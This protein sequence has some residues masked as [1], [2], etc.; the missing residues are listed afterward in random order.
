MSQ[1]G[2]GAPVAFF[3]PYRFDLSTRELRKGGLR[4]RLEGKPALILQHL[5]EHAGALVTREEL[6]ALLW[7]PGVHVD[8][9]HGLNKAINRLRAVL[10]DDREEPRYIETLSRRGYRFVA[11]LEFREE[12]AEAAS[13][14]AA[15]VSAAAER[16]AENVPALVSYPLV[17]WRVA[18]AA[19]F[20]LLLTSVTYV[21][22][23]QLHADANT[24]HARRIVVLPFQNLT[25]DEGQEYFCDGLTDELTAQLGTL[26][27]QKLQVLARTSGR[28]YKRSTLTAGQIGK[29]LTSQYV[30]GGSVRRVGSLYRITVQLTDAQSQANIWS[31]AFDREFKDVLDVHRDVSLA[32]GREIGDK[33]LPQFQHPAFGAQPINPLAHDAYLRGRFYWNK[34]TVTDLRN[35]VDEFRRAI[36]ID[37]DYAEAHAGLAD[38]YSLLAS[39]GAIPFREGY[40]HARVEAE[41]ALQLNPHSAEARTSLAFIEAYYDWKFEQADQDFLAATR[42]N[43]NY[44]TGHHWYGLF[45]SQRGRVL[46]AINEL[47]M[48]ERLDPF[49]LTIGIDLGNAYATAGRYEDA[50][51]QFLKVRALDFHYYGTY[52]AMC[53]LYT[54]QNRLTEA[55]RENETLKKLSG[56]YFGNDHILAYAYAKAGQTQRARELLEQ[57]S[58]TAREH[59]SRPPCPIDAYL[60]L[61][62]DAAALNCLDQGIQERADWLVPLGRDPEFAKVASDARFEARLKQAGLI[63]AS[64][65]IGGGR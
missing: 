19:L 40:P 64:R 7:A 61:H 18:V 55:E 31:G 26:D 16:P 13:A 41:K 23:K 35:S 8:F 15:A 45:L 12:R 50:Q 59:G 5:I 25:G 44:T 52:G 51:H 30:L 43:P 21:G 4:L 33:V 54:L 42:E 9:N 28:H 65:T 56:N 3:G 22:W 1:L 29:E 36:A 57:I 62:D 24:K 6:Q 47:A 17:R 63:P 49:S 34:R 2:D 20:V 53:W 14:S 60:A 48:A 58:R 37:A 39:Y 11:Q 46:E 38:A 10:G 32:V 27:P